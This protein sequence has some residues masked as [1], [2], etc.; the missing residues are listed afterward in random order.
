MLVTLEDAD[1]KITKLP[2]KLHLVPDSRDVMKGADSGSDQEWPCDLTAHLRHAGAQSDV[3]REFN[4][5]RTSRRATRLPETAFT[6]HFR[7]CFSCAKLLTLIS[8]LRFEVDQNGQFIFKRAGN[9]LPQ[10]LLKRPIDSL[11]GAYW[12]WRR[13]YEDRLGFPSVLPARSASPPLSWKRGFRLAPLSRAYPSD[14]PIRCGCAR[15][16]LTC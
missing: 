5:D 10:P 14:R 9:A 3:E 15:A 1:N 8:S 6:E 7:V 13:R 16:P 4:P 11:R 2:K 12:T